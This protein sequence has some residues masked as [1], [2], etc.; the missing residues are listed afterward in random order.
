[1]SSSKARQLRDNFQPIRG[2]VSAVSALFLTLVIIIY[3]IVKRIRTLHGHCIGVMCFFLSLVFILHSLLQFQLIPS[4]ICEP[5]TL[6]SIVILLLVYFTLKLMCVEVLRLLVSNCGSD[7]FWGIIYNIY[8]ILPVVL[9][10]TLYEFLKENTAADTFDEIFGYK[11]CWLIDLYL[12]KLLFLGP[13]T[14][15][16]ILDLVIII[17]AFCTLKSNSDSYYSDEELYLRNNICTTFKVWIWMLICWIGELLP[18]FLKNIHDLEEFVWIAADF[19]W[20][21]QGVVLFIILVSCRDRI[22][23]GL[24]HASCLEHLLPESWKYLDDDEFY[25][26]DSI[27]Y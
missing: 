22:L 20:A 2:I 18:F 3:L 7:Y 4:D 1:M 27:L 6:A 11:G 15:L 19:L 14:A 21:S 24:S 8:L 13:I 5:V 10:F 26:Q 9:I 25:D 16:F 17:F 12:F 23:A